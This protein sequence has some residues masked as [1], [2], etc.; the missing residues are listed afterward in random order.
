MIKS[1][2]KLIITV[3][4]IP[5]TIIIMAIKGASLNA[6]YLNVG[7]RLIRKGVGFQIGQPWVL[8][9][10]GGRPPKKKWIRNAY[11]NFKDNKVTALYSDR[12]IPGLSDRFTKASK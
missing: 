8:P 10:P 5:F 12:P 11:L 1:I 2:C 3:F 7:T 9:Q 4:S 6:I